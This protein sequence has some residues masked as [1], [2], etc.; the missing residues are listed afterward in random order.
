MTKY[1]KY[2]IYDKC[3]TKK[4]NKLEIN[5]KNFYVNGWVNVSSWERWGK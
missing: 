3:I 4:Y 1:D 5:V 2:H